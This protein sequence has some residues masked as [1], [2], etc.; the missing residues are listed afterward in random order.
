MIPYHTA[1]VCTATFGIK[2]VDT[3]KTF[4]SLARIIPVTAICAVAAF[5]SSCDRVDDTRIP[6]APVNIVFSNVGMWNTYGVGG[7]LD[8]RVFDI[9]VKPRLPQGFPY[10]VSSAT[11]YGG[12]LLVCDYYNNP[13]AYDRSCPV[14]AR[15]DVCV[16]VTDDH[17]AECPVC[18]S[19]YSIFENYGYPLSGLAAERGYSLRRYYVVDGTADYKVIVR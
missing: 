1:D 8:W 2:T 3:V 7:A 19:T 6:A 4:S 17:V 9:N 16:Y 10:A 5:I 18:H 12:V 13:L 14:E 15:R 11:G